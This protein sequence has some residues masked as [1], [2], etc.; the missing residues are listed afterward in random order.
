[1]TPAEDPSVNEANAALRHAHAWLERVDQQTT[2]YFGLDH[3]VGKND[4]GC[5]LCHAVAALEGRV[6]PVNPE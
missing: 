2:G 6:E 5:T 4:D 1:M 3:Q